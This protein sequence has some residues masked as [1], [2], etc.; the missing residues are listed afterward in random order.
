MNEHT[1]RVLEFNTILSLLKGLVTSRLGE[2]LCESLKPIS[3]RKQIATL[4]DEVSELKEILQNYG[5]IPIGGIMDVEESIKKT[6]VQGAALEPVKILEICSTLNATHR[7]KRFFEKLE[8]DWYPLTKGIAK[9][10]IALPEIEHKIEKTIGDRGDILD[11]ASS[12]LNRIRQEIKKCKAKIQ[13]YLEG[14]FASSSFQPFFQEKIITI[15][16]G[17]YVIPVKSDFKGHIQGI[18]HDHSHSKATCFI[19]PIATI[20]L[21]N[22]L[23]LISKEEKDEE[24]RVLQELTSRIQANASEILSNLKL[25]GKID[26]TFAKAKFSIH[27][28]ARRPALNEEMQVNLINA[29]HPL[30][31]FFK[32]RYKGKNKPVNLTSDVVPID[33]HF[34]KGCSTLIITGANTGGKT[35]ALKTAGILT[36]MVQAGIHIPVKDGSSAAIFDS[37]FADVGDEQDIE[38]NLSTFSSHILQIIEILEKAD[39]RSLVLLDEIGVGTDPDEG[40]A[41]SIALLDYLK[42]KKASIIATTHLNLLKAYAYLHEDV[43]NVS[44]AFDPETMEPLYR[45]VYGASGESNALVIAKKLGIPR[46][47]LNRASGFLKE[48]NK[49]VSSLIGALEKTQ[50]EIIKEKEEIESLKGIHIVYQK[51]LESLL[52]HFNKKEERLLLECVNKVESL[53]K[54]A[55]H[56]AKE[57]LKNVKKNGHAFSNVKGRL[58][59]IREDF[60]TYRPKRDKESFLV[61]QVGDLVKITPLNKEGVI[62]NIHG[63]LD[64]VE[65][66]IGDLKVKV[67]VSDLEQA[68]LDKKVH[69]YRATRNRSRGYD[70]WKEVF[71]GSSVSEMPGKVN[72]VGLR[73]DEAI[74]LVD[75]AIDNAVLNGITRL[76]IVHGIG[77]GRLREAIRDHLKLHN[78]IDNFRAADLS[79]GGA[80]VTIA[81]IKA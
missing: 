55:E 61:P 1:L 19:E 79:Q 7:L 65:V 48:S 33:I 50:K 11:S 39:E 13:R 52:D 9:R 2:S 66:L 36:L 76:D 73:V 72:V 38:Q 23:G 3:D 47:I 77:T 16:N 27:L 58:N 78:Y 54:K 74:P 69:N 29:Y 30:L 43:T 17:R 20:E 14:L 37:I 18:I 71:V 15:R 42:E 56:E 10:L 26:L 45:L 28:D 25:L 81:D 40:A 67:D 8:G 53:L 51:Q 75:K 35:V 57:I 22:E 6:R 46:E 49:G 31:L 44:V 24:I 21:N 12:K 63:G 80:G 5:D 64:K 68:S 34:D 59:K 32:D 62:L 60:E 41:L 70:I 4:L